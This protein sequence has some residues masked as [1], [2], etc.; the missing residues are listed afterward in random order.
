MLNIATHH[1]LTTFTDMTGE[2][3]RDVASATSLWI[4]YAWPLNGAFSN[5]TICVETWRLVTRREIINGKNALHAYSI[6]LNHDSLGAEGDLIA[7]SFISLLCPQWKHIYVSICMYRHTITWIARART[8]NV[9]DHFNIKV[10]IFVYS[11]IEYWRL[12]V[13]SSKTW[14]LWRPCNQ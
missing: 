7:L 12:C 14:L 6:T 4:S 11:P 9:M 1:P 10:K 3:C 5:N 8:V 13:M 2:S